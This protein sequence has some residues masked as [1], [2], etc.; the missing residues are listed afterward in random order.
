V[1]PGIAPAI[2]KPLVILVGGLDV[3]V[4]IVPETGKGALPLGSVQIIGLDV[5]GHPIRRLCHRVVTQVVAVADM[6]VGP[7]GQPSI[8]VFLDELGLFRRQVV[9]VNRIGDG[10]RRQCHKRPANKGGP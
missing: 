9:K 10:H 4:G 5:E 1:A 7:A 3:D 8:N 6:D 2:L